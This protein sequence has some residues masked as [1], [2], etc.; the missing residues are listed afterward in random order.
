MKVPLH[1][2]FCFQK[3]GTAFLLYYEGVFFYIGVPFHRRDVV[4][5]VASR[6]A[7][8]LFQSKR[9]VR[10]PKVLTLGGVFFVPKKR[11]FE[12]SDLEG[13]RSIDLQGGPLNTRNQMGILLMAETGGEMTLFSIYILQ[14]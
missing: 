11:I 4:A 1:L 12:G 5:F 7:M 10:H 14:I 3:R 6:N 13:G 9:S 2:Q 8:S